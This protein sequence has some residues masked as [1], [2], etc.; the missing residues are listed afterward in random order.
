MVRATIFLD[1]VNFLWGSYGSNYIRAKCCRD[2]GN[3]WSPQQIVQTK[4]DIIC[5]PFAIWTAAIP[6]PP[7]AAVTKTH[8]PEMPENFNTKCLEGF[9][10]CHTFL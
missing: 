6:T 9:V 2:M 8:S 1:D 7:A 4:G 5:I 3:Q 10:L